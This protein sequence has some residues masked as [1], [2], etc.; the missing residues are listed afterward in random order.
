MKELNPTEVHLVSG[1]ISFSWDDFGA[2]TARGAVTGGVG[3]A[4]SGVVA[5]PGVG[6]IPG[7]IA[8]TVVGGISGSLGYCA[9]S[10]FS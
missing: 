5:I 10:L 2:S 8:G 7:W 4:I 9:G 1:A 3:G 6:S